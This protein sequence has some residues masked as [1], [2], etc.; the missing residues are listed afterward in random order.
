MIY[1]LFLYFCFAIKSKFKNMKKI[2]KIIGIILLVIMITGAG[3]VTY[4]KTALPNVGA[5]PELKV[6]RTPERI[7]RGKYIANHITLC[8][9]CHSTRDWTK[10]AG[11]MVDGTLGKG[12]ETF[13]QKFGFPGKFYSRNITP[14]GIARYTDGELFRLITTGVTKEGHPMF[15][16]MPYTH[17]GK[18][19]P[20]DIN[21]I[22]A[23]IR[24]F[25]PLQ[26][27]VPQS[28][29]DFP[30]NIILNTIP[31]KATPGK[32]PDPSSVKEYGAYIANAAA[33]VECHTKDEHGRIIQAMAYSGGREFLLPDGSIVRS[34]NITPDITSGIGS[35]TKEAFINRFKAYADSNYKPP[36][37][38][39]GAFN[40]IM[41][42]HM[43]AGMTREDL[44]A[45]YEYIHSLP[46]QQNVVVKFTP[47]K[48][49][50]RK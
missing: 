28:V 47:A 25:A 44:G 21:C 33:C 5:A 41:P 13:D 45:I 3:L 43:Y 32:K 46:A 38:V 49:I 2:F 48:D 30:M 37:V 35:W 6:E 22:I 40:T 42:W 9:D 34:C 19:D 26:N 50:V 23:Y 39:N 31:S 14:Y 18:M 27:D 11:P 16:I 8:V 10:F 24:S 7:E 29:A 4:V 36:T 17:Y 12:G 1:S 15:P 20:E